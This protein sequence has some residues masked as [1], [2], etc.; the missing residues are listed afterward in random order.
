MDI[1]QRIKAG[2]VEPKVA[3]LLELLLYK[4]RLMG[5]QVLLRPAKKA[6]SC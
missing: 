3:N 2:E 1:Q 4:T 6:T 5:G